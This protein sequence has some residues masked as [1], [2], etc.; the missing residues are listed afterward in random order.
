MQRLKM[1]NLRIYIHELGPIRNAEIELAPVM[2]FTGASNLGKSYTNFLAYYVLSLFSGNRLTEFFRKK[3]P[4]EVLSS[5]RVDFSFSVKEL[6]DWMEVDVKNF[7]VYLLNYP[8]VP[9]KVEFCFEDTDRAFHVRIQQAKTSQSTDKLGDFKIMILSIDRS[10]IAFLSRN[11]EIAD[12]AAIHIAQYLQK[13]LLDVRINHAYL[14][15]PGRASLLNESFSIKKDVSNTGMYDIFLNDFDYIVNLKIRSNNAVDTV[16]NKNV[17]ELT[18]NIIEGKLLSTKEGIVMNVKGQNNPIPISA[19]ASSIKELSPFLLWV[20]NGKLDVD[21]MCIEEPEAH[22]HPEMQYGIADLMAA[23]IMQGTL[24][25]ITTHSD[26]LLA[27][28]NQLIRLHNLKQKDSNRFKDVCQTYGINESL[29]LDP[30][31]IHAYFFHKN[32]ESQ[33]VTIEK[34]D[35]KDGIP[36]DT[37]SNAVQQQID[38]NQIF[39]EEQSDETL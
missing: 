34:M 20:E 28:L 17:A 29:T 3:M 21:S 12:L 15:P 2:I 14:L 11:D 24:M 36:F 30:S 5:N 23:C 19:T 9:C 37:F 18:E 1:R 8:D 4:E 25:Q 33:E 6:K 35:V 26:Y 13:E 39:N 10:N 31:L 16:R 7:F 32:K 22:A 38:W 27:R